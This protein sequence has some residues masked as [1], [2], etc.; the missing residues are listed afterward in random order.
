ML[1]IDSKLLETVINEFQINPLKSIN[2]QLIIVM[3]YSAL[4]GSKL[5]W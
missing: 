4:H 3:H 2:N 1:M 5:E